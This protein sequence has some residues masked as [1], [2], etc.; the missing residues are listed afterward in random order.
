MRLYLG[1]FMALM[2]HSLVSEPYRRTSAGMGFDA[3]MQMGGKL[4][5][6]NSICR[7]RRGLLLDQGK[8]A[9]L[10]GGATSHKVAAQIVGKGTSLHTH[11]YVASDMCRYVCSSY[12]VNSNS[13]PSEKKKKPTRNNSCNCTEKASFTRHLR[14]LPYQSHRSAT[15]RNSIPNSPGRWRRWWRRQDPCPNSR[16]E[17][18]KAAEGS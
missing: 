5:R 1:F 3:P 12:A 8:A 6:L 16:S 17:T 15:C 13:S 14:F 18:Y 11:E 9:I 7:L 4:S 10:R 2:A